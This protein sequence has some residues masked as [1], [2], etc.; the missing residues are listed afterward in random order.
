MLKKELQKKTASRA[1]DHYRLSPTIMVFYIN[2]VFISYGYLIKNIPYARHLSVIYKY[3]VLV[4]SK[5]V[6]KMQDE[7]RSVLC[8]N[9][10]ADDY[11]CKFYPI[12]RVYLGSNMQKDQ[13]REI[14]EICKRKRIPYTGVVKSNEKYQ[15]I[16]GYGCSYT[17]LC[18]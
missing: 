12:T 3:G 6:W 4:K 7:W 13:R 2:A 16:E 11:N 8:D 17:H 18:R 1:F 14:I 10:L 9:M 15:M 5:S